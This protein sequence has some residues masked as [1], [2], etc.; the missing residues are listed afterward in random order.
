MALAAAG[1][2]SKLLAQS[3]HGSR[4]IIH[5]FA[6]SFI[7]DIVANAY[8]HGVACYGLVLLLKPAIFCSSGQD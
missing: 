6:D 4:A 7:R 8:D 1:T 3:R 2:D 5:R